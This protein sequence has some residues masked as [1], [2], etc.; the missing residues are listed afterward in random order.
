MSD[1]ATGAPVPPP[2]ASP[3]AAVEPPARRVLLYLAGQ[4]GWNGARPWGGAQLGADVTVAA[5]VFLALS[6]TYDQTWER[7]GRGIVGQRSAA[8]IGA[9]VAAP[10]VPDRLDLRVRLALE[11]QELRASI[12]QPS[13]HREDAAGRG[14]DRDRGGVDLALPI[15]SGLAVFAGG[16]FDWWG[17]QTTVR[18]Q[19]AP[20]ETIGAWMVSVACAGLNVRFP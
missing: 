18:V 9:G 11:L 19:G 13:T 6:A 15:T 8:G 4:T 17:G 5:P 20:D 7:D 10:L 1:V 12:D 3:P 16:R 14:V 2:P